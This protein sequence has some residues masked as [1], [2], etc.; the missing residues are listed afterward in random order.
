[1]ILNPFLCFG[2]LTCDLGLTISITLQHPVKPLGAD[3]LISNVKAI[4]AGRV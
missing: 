3:L 1:M 2:D 4:Y